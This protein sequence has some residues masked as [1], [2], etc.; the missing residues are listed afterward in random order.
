[1]RRVIQKTFE[2][3]DQ[4]TL[5]R[6][7][8]DGKFIN[9]YIMEPPWRNN[10]VN[11]SCIPAGT[12]LCKW[13]KSPHYG[14]VYLITGVADRTNVLKHPGN[15]GGDKKKGFKTNTLACQLHGKRH[16]KLWNGKFLQRAILNSR[17]AIRE[18]FHML[19]GEDF[20]LEVIR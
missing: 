15:F 12:Y 9:Q 5:S 20:I 6:V 2:S 17:S 13:H 7:F 8:V 11:Y 10:E 14:W 1:M 19:D 16:G 4:G 3:T 18:F